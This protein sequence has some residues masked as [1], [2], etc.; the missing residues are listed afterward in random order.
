MAATSA[1]NP[2]LNWGAEG[3]L[4]LGANALSA[5]DQLVGNTG[6]SWGRSLLYNIFTQNPNTP[7]FI[8][9]LLQRS[10][11]ASSAP[12][13]GSFTIGELEPEYEAAISA[14][15]PISTWPLDN[16]KRW[17]V[18]VDGYDTT[19][20]VSRS[21]SSSVSGLARGKAVA[22][23]DSGTTYT[24]ASEEFCRNL[25]SG[26][27]GATFSSALGQWVVPC[28]QEVNIGFSIGG[29]RFPMHPLDTTSPSVTG[30]DNN[31]CYGTFLPQTFSA[32]AGEFDI[33]LGDVFLRNVYAMFDLGDWKDGQ[34]NV[35]GN[36]YVK[37]LSLTNATAA[38][39]EF[40]KLR[41]GSATEANK[42]SNAQSSVS[43]GSSSSTV[44]VGSDKL[45]YLIRYAEVMLS[46]LTISTFLLVLAVGM[47]VYV[48]F[49][50]HKRPVTSTEPAA[51]SGTSASAS[52]LGLGLHLRP[53][54]PVYQ[55]VPS[56][57]SSVV[58]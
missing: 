40:H 10:E 52:A 24:Y 3:L 51:D 39:T 45:N 7:N 58:P 47:L 48:V 46:L 25:Y 54:G 8:A 5:I 16:S 35:M 26:I 49:F 23:L 28:N 32:G 31:T 36:P 55:Q 38:S 15:E 6:N 4:G 30:T 29:R 33:L 50:K 21:L 17:T 13:E 11:D 27:P 12:T 43:S 57:R 20:A 19:G 18:V 1:N 14:T 22:L 9:F 2:I 37:L 41:G 53:P 44:S 34:T 56:A 42:I